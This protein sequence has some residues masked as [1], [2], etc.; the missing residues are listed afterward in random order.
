MLLL[1]RCAPEEVLEIADTVGMLVRCASKRL[2]LEAA[3]VE[4]TSSAA[5]FA[6]ELLEDGATVASRDKNAP[7]EESGASVVLDDV[8]F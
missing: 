4:L 1:A 8:S 6:F 7:S 2:L 3:S 5:A